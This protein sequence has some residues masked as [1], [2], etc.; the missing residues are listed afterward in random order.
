MSKAAVK[1]GG[2]SREQKKTKPE[3]KQDLKSF[4]AER[5]PEF[6]DNAMPQNQREGNDLMSCRLM[7]HLKSA[8][9]YSRCLSY[10]DGRHFSVASPAEAGEF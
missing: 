4:T 10:L 5:K 2:E 1:Q 3:Q 9:K 7:G 6:T 8:E